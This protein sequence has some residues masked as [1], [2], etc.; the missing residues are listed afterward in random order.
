MHYKTKTSRCNFS[1]EQDKAIVSE[2][3]PAATKKGEEEVDTIVM[4]TKLKIIEILKVIFLLW[5]LS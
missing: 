2:V 4:D 3:I 1:V 5:L